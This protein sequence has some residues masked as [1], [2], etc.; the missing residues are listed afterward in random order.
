M[1]FVISLSQMLGANSSLD[2]DSFST[3]NEIISSSNIQQQ[4]ES[5]LS[6]D[7][8]ESTRAYNSSLVTLNRKSIKQISKHNCFVCSHS[9]ATISNLRRHIRAKHKTELC[10]KCEICGKVYET[11]RGLKLHA[12][13]CLDRQIIN[14]KNDFRNFESSLPRNDKPNILEDKPA[15]VIIDLCDETSLGSIKTANISRLKPSMILAFDEPDDQMS[16][17]LAWIIKQ[18]NTKPSIQRLTEIDMILFDPLLTEKYKSGLNQQQHGD[19]FEESLINWFDDWY[20]SPPINFLDDYIKDGKIRLPL[21]SGKRNNTKAELRTLFNKIAVV[22]GHRVNRLEEISA[23]FSSK[24]VDL[25]MSSISDPRWCSKLVYIWA[26][27]FGFWLVRFKCCGFSIEELAQTVIKLKSGATIWMYLKNL[28]AVSDQ[29]IAKLKSN[30]RLGIENGTLKEMDVLKKVENLLLYRSISTKLEQLLLVKEF[31]KSKAAVYAKHLLVLT[32]ITSVTQRAQVYSSLIWGKSLRQNRNGNWEIIVDAFIDKAGRGAITII[33]PEINRFWNHYHQVVYPCL[34]KHIEKDKTA[35]KNVNMQEWVFIGTINYR[36]K[37]S[38]GLNTWV[39]DVTFS[40][41]NRR[42]PISKFRTNC[43]T[44]MSENLHYSS[45]EL[46]RMAPLSSH[47]P[48][49]QREFYIKRD[50]QSLN[51][52]FNHDIICF[53]QSE[54]GNVADE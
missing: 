13:N 5:R 19:D 22:I 35:V 53:L 23:M 25:V 50:L 48:E 16:P 32:L 18:E 7:I 20:R 45:D 33:N 39:K 43:A 44:R 12:N 11:I 26:K 52:K 4:N 27:F 6:A 46:S 15:E 29:K 10:H 8:P 3:V 14:E 51:Q 37:T 38:K 42:V 28:K 54:E 31:C 17:E 36:S 1:T 40:I 2:N 30:K 24:V 49:V 21:E 9:F 41:I 34:R 47:T